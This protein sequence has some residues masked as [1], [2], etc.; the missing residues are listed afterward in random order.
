MRCVG[1]A[2]NKEVCFSQQSVALYPHLT[3]LVVAVPSASYKD[4]LNGLCVV[5]MQRAGGGGYNAASAASNA[6]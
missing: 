6:E 3:K 4:T 1:N 5:E 2:T